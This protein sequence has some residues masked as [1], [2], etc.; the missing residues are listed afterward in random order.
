MATVSYPHISLDAAGVPILTGTRIKVVEVVLDHLAHGSDAD[1]IRRQFPHLTLGQIHSALGYY[2]DH[3]EEVDQ[4]IAR[5]LREVDEIQARLENS[6]LA[7]RLRALK[8]L[9]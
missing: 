7:R 8:K 9:P 5:G 6:A 4:E 2:Y 1:E 3:Q